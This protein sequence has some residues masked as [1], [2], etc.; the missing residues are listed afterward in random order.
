MA[1]GLRINIDEKLG[2]YADEFCSFMTKGSHKSLI[3]S[4]SQD[5]I[6]VG[7]E[8]DRKEL[9]V[10]FV[11]TLRVLDDND[12][13]Q[14]RLPLGRLPLTSISHAT[15]GFPR[16][17][18]LRDG[19]LIPLYQRE[20]M[21]ISFA[22]S[23]G[24]P[25]ALKVLCGSVNALSGFCGDDRASP[26]QDYV[27][28][29]TQHRLDGYL[30]QEEAVRQFIAM[31]LGFDYSVEMQRTGR[32]FIGGIQLVVAP[33]IKG[34]RIF[35][36]FLNQTSKT[37]RDLG[38]AEYQHLRI[39]GSEVAN[40]P[41]CIRNHDS[42]FGTNLTDNVDYSSIPQRRELFINEILQSTSDLSKSIPIQLE[43]V[44]ALKVHLIADIPPRSSNDGRTQPRLKST[45]EPFS[46]FASF[47]IL[48]DKVE[49]IFSFEV[50]EL[51]ENGKRIHYERDQPLH[52]RLSEKA[53]VLVRRSISLGNQG[54]VRCHFKNFSF[55]NRR[56]RTPMRKR[57]VKNDIKSWELSLAAG[58]LIQQQVYK[59]KNPERWNW[60]KSKVINVVL[61]NTA[62]YEV[63]T[64]LG[65]PPSPVTTEAYHREELPYIDV[66]FSESLSAYGDLKQLVS[67]Q[68]IDSMTGIISDRTTRNGSQVVVCIHCQKNVA[69]TM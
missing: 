48:E 17:P 51:F 24:H 45:I 6:L 38:L 59:D 65:P 25:Y 33:E 34:L 53:I 15:N 8:K 3:L 27:V 19:V 10:S 37:P 68:Q 11:R 56:S 28:A 32:E 13:K 61:L 18:K 50:V 52:S 7:N 4:K 42:S 22:G 43:P 41:E 63:F 47:K 57:I 36:D 9:S 29:P 23:Y 44:Y 5:E 2:K 67:V 66:M 31:P 35:P 12:P 1:E 49:Q 69:D 55:R 39:E 14:P 26:S 16:E 54:Q 30:V 20:A 60:D 46:P 62:A 58:G 21:A 64:G 40:H